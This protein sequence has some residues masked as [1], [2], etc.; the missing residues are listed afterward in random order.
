[1]KSL[2]ASIAILGV[3]G[4]AVGTGAG[5]ADV[6]ATVTPGVIS[7][8]LDRAAVAYGTIGSMAISSFQ[9]QKESSR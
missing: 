5:A 4:L 2:I 8:S 6:V 7:V 3:V 1:M 9:Q